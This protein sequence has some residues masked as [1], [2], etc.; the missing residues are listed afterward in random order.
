MSLQS[1]G[2]RLASLNR[3]TSTVM[4]RVDVP[5][6]EGVAIDDGASWGQVVPK[7]FAIVSKQ[8]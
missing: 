2:T 8:V 1:S 4:L 6:A 7:S 3:K 5:V